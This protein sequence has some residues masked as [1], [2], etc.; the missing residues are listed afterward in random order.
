MSVLTVRPVTP[1]EFG[2]WDD[3]VESS[4]QGT[5]FHTSFWKRVI[6]PA[7]APAKL[8]LVGCYDERH[9]VAGC[10][11]LLRER[12]GH[13]TAVTPLLTPYAGFILEPPLGEKISDQVSRAGSHL[14][15]LA[16]WLAEKCP[17][18]N[19]VNPPHLDDTRPL[20]E[21]GY[22]L[23]PRFTY[24][25]NLKL[26]AEEIWQGF[27]GSVRRQIRKAERAGFEIS[28]ELDA[29]EAF[30]MFRG[31]FA[32]RGEGCPVTKAMFASVAADDKLRDFRL[33]YGAREA[34][35]LVSFIVLLRH[36]RTVYY[37]LAATHPD[38]L[39]SGVSSLLI[40]EV[41][42]AHACDAW[43]VFDFVGANIPSI[44]RFKEGFNP[45]L[46][47]HYQT[48]F[49]GPVL[50]RLGKTVLDLLRG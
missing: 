39:S 23:T 41:I 15:A 26:P 40:W 29:D 38:H 27:D 14:A 25:I 9:L 48:E 18:Q 17:Y 34:G 11:F 44:A 1:N 10:V 16:E 21:A 19:L 6:D 49:C 20:Q 50:V 4:P 5:L 8:E 36:N 35:R 42:K 30:E 7:N 24:H 43:N 3:F 2:T 37:S 32:R 28:D 31:V 46:Q 22:R 13:A 47:T 12:Y 45:R 33:V